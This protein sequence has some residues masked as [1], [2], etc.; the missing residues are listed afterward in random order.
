MKKLL[1]VTVL[2]A[3]AAAHA[4]TLTAPQMIPGVDSAATTVTFNSPFMAGVATTIANTPGTTVYCWTSTPGTSGTTPTATVPGICDGAPTL[5]YSALAQMTGTVTNCAI[6]TQTGQI[7]SAMTCLTYNLP[8]FFPAPNN[9]DYTPVPVQLSGPQ[10]S[11]LAFTVDGSTPTQSGCSV[12]HGTSLA[13][14]ATITSALTVTTTIKFIYWATGTCTS[15][16]VQTGLYTLG[17]KKTVYIRADGGTR[18]TAA[19]PTGQCNGFYDASYASTGG[20]GVNQNC[21][22][23]DVRYLWDDNNGT[24]TWVPAGGDDILV[25]GCN[26]LP[27]QVYPSNP[28]CRLGWDTNVNGNPPNSWASGAGPYGAFNL[29]PI[30]SGSASQPTRFLGQ[31]YATCNSGGSN[32]N[33]PATYKTNLNQLFGGFALAI[34][35]D[36]RGT[37]NVVFECLEFTTHNQTTPTTAWASGTNYSNTGYVTYLGNQYSSLQNGNQNNNPASSPTFWLLSDN[38]VTGGAPPYPR[39]C[40]TSPPTLDDFASNGMLFNSTSANIQF[41][42][43]YAHGWSSSAFFGPIGGP[44]T[45]TRVNVSNNRFAAFNFDDGNSSPNSPITTFGGVATVGSTLTANYVEMDG[46]GCAEEYPMVH[47]WPWRVCYDTNSQGFGDTW[48]GQ[49]STMDAITINH[50]IAQ[51]NTKDA[52]IGP[53]TWTSSINIQNSFQQGNMGQSWK[54]GGYYFPNNTIFLNNLTVANCNRMSQP[55]TGAPSNYNQF[56]TGFCRAAGNVVASAIPTSSTWLIANNTWV[57]YQPTIFDIACPVGITPCTST[58]DFTNNA[59]LGYVNPSNPYGAVTPAIYYI[60]DA[61]ITGVGSHNVQYGVRNGDTS[62]S[63]GNLT[64]D[65]LFVSEPA[66]GSVPPESTLDNFDFHPSGSSPLLAAG[67]TYPPNTVT[68]DYY[69]TAATS[70]LVVGAANQGAAPTLTSITVLPNPASATTGGTVN[71]ATSS[72][73]GYS[74]GPTVPAGTGSCTPAWTTTGAHSSINS[75][76]G[77]ATGVSVGSDTETATIG[78]ITGTATLNV[79]AVTPGMS[80]TGTASYTGM[81]TGPH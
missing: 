25:H 13:N 1:F 24:H 28:N 40:N 68:T 22:F 71:L 60:E 26:A 5:T 70:P 49:N 36:V 8:A 46:N 61:S 14:G 27:S 52:F 35:L 12:T 81:G 48:S 3:V 18:Y 78:M 17:S 75:S 53:H 16:G 76:T 69:G 59:T 23:N 44:F 64:A 80:V 4:V 37:Q 21:A 74:S 31:N 19:V 15:S 65:P 39:S 10:G 45:F 9:Y 38:C 29:L 41:I 66:Q 47:T 43:F 63:N 7:N 42:D 32:P 30:P 58:V 77:I 54:W 34:G 20:T 11:N 50:Y 79:T 62:G 72:Y 73:C 2:L 56:L 6:A 57:T 67:T 55:L 51:F 33:N